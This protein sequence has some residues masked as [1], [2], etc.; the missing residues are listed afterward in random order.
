MA[1]PSTFL[2][3][4][5]FPT[6]ERT[7]CPWQRALLAGVLIL[8]AV[9]VLWFAVQVVHGLLAPTAGAASF[10]GVV[11]QQLAPMLP[12]VYRAFFFL[13]LLLTALFLFA[14]LYRVLLIDLSLSRERI[15]IAA[16]EL[17]PPPG[18]WP[19]YVIQ[20]PL[21]KEASALPHLVEAIGRLDYPT[22]RLTVQLLIEADD[23]ETWAALEQIDLVHPFTVVEVPVS[24]PR[25]KPKACN[26]GLASAAGDYLVI[27]D[28]EDRPD[29]DQLKKAVIAFS[30]CG[31]EV[32]CIQ[33]RLSFYNA[34]HNLL[35]R[36][37]TA[38]YAMWFDL[39]LPGLD[40]LHAPIP[41]GGT[42]NHFRLDI[43]KRL[44]GWDEYNVTEDCDLGLRLFIR[45]WRT[46]M[47]DSTTW[48][49]AC[50]RLAWWIRQR[51]RWVKGYVQTYLVHTR[52]F[53]NLTRRLGIANSAH[54]HLLIG[55]AVLFQLVSTFYWLLVLVWLI[56][57]PEVVGMFFPGAIF[58]MAALCLFLGNFAFV[59]ASAIACMRLGFGS[60]V[61]YTPLLVLYWIVM[62]LAAW[63]GTL[64]LISRPHFWEKTQHLS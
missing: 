27:Y 18:G 56:F 3:P 40:R 35:T 5:G 57:R 15:S 42:S 51:S 55:G 38:E 44:Q 63:K 50:P 11:W 62:S 45:G 23:T 47:L 4:R 21:Y 7:L 10:L 1:D 6:A 54:F 48:E 34:G 53:G 9:P 64:Q 60:V 37:F 24:Q 58:V 52:D 19:R 25:T 17:Q 2:G 12:T 61:K 8:L 14:A 20:V 29:P 59:Y 49:E 36:C 30:R 26:V 31:E 33:A 39:C 28:A 32:A 43:L 22:D 46:R 41:L 13:N 16:D